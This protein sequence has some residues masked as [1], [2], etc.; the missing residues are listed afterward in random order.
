LG[1]KIG[2]FLNYQCYSQFFSK[3]SF[4]LTQKRQFFAKFFG[5]NIFKII[6][7]VPEGSFLKQA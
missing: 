1:K 2:V 7:S 4:V 3:F 5:E 6:A